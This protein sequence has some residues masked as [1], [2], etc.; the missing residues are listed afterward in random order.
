METNQSPIYRYRGQSVKAAHASATLAMAT[1]L[2]KEP[3][4][5]KGKE[6]HD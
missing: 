3:N 2:N 1:R 5:P 4:D 6:N